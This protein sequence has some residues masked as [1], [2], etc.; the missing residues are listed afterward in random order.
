MLFYFCITNIRMMEASEEPVIEQAQIVAKPKKSKR[1]LYGMIAL[2]IAV[3]I[4]FLVPSGKPEAGNETSD[5]A[6]TE[7]TISAGKVVIE[8]YEAKKRLIGKWVISGILSNT[9]DAPIESIEFEAVFS[10]N[11]EFISY[12]QFIKAGET[13]HEFSIKVSGHKGENLNAFKIR[14]VQKAK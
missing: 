12:D 5:L 7:S 10:D 1:K 9:S 4:Y 3:I 13:N 14:E 6:S 8:S 2:V 11:T